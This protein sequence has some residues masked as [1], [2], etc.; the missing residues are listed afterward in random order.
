[1]AHLS[2]MRRMTPSTVLA[3]MRVPNSWTRHMRTC[4]W[5]HPFGVR[6]HISRTIGSTSGLDTCAGR[7]R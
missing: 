7:D 5:P 2:P 3:D 1:M 6:S 4:R